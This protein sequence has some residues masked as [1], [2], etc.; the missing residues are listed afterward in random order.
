QGFV[1]GQTKITNQLGNLLAAVEQMD[2]KAVAAQLKQILTGTGTTATTAG[3]TTAATAMQGGITTA[4]GGTTATVNANAILSEV[5][6]QTAVKTL[7]HEPQ[8]TQTEASQVPQAPQKTEVPQI[9]SQNNIPIEKQVQAQQVAQI[10]QAAQPESAQSAKSALPL[11]NQTAQSVQTLNSNLEPTT[12]AK[13]DFSALQ[14][15]QQAKATQTQTVQMQATQISQAEKLPLPPNLLFT[16]ED[17]TPEKI[18]RYLNNL[19]EIMSNVIQAA[20][21][22]PNGARVLQEARAVEAQIDFAAQIKNQ[23]FVQLPIFHNE[24][25]TLAN[26]HIYKDAKKSAKGEDI[27]SALIAL[28]TASMGHFETYVRKHARAIHCQFRLESDE[29]VAAVRNNIH[30]LNNLLRESGYSLES[31]TFLPPGEPYSVLSDPAKT[32]T[33]SLDE[34]TF[35]DKRV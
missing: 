32:Q 7:I 31:F 33:S 22:S 35:F 27:S 13:Q 4:Q 5:T 21:K 23:L 8:N 12:Q 24:R 26:L 3:T 25:Q 20:G 1:G 29:I 6:V 15:A 17:S 34:M 14:T 18:E 28:E 16:L 30:E 2:D 10:P 9:N 11:Q 19:R